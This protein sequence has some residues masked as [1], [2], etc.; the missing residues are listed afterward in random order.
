MAGVRSSHGYLLLR[1]R[2][3]R[4][5]DVCWLCGKSINKALPYK[6]P[7]TGQVNRWSWSLDHVVPIDE[8]PDLA[9]DRSNARAAHV[10]CNN[11]RGKRPPVRHAST[12][13]LATSR[14]W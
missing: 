14:S 1:R 4:E 7:T 2:V 3:R 5:E 8:R 10:T 9:L 13:P 6:D 11:A 12:A